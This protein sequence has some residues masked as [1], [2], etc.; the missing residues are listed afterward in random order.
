[1]NPRPSR[2]ALRPSTAFL[3]LTLLAWGLASAG[4]IQGEAV[5]KDR[6]G[7][8]KDP[9]EEPV[10]V[11]IDDLTAPVP[12]E[13]LEREYVMI[14]ERKQFSP[15]IMAVPR[16]AAVKFPNFDPIIH[17]VFSVSGKNRFDAGRYSRDEGAEHVFQYPGMARIYCNVHHQ[18][19]A[20]I[21]IVDNPFFAQTDDQGRFFIADVPAGEYRL[22]AVHRVAGSQ[23]KRVRV[24]ADGRVEVLFELEVKVRR[25][26]RHLNKEGKPYKRSSERY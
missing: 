8:E 13:L 24:A 10:L 5:V 9:A 21:Y 25:L 4:D 2:R 3:W 1:M 23:T 26:K 15:R 6:R 18:M 17:N 14:T 11:F 19:N 7:R 20:V 16:G 22:T 12:R